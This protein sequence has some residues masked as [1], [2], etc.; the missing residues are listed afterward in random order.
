MPESIDM[1]TQTECKREQH[2]PD[3][4]IQLDHADVAS[5]STLLRWDKNTQTQKLFTSINKFLTEFQDGTV[6]KLENTFVNAV[7]NLLGHK[8]KPQTYK[9][10]LGS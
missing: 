10:R 8:I 9:I 5:T 4:C 3:K 2:I 7:E 6:Q 1:S